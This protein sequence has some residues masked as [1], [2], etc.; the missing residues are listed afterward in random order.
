VDTAVYNRKDLGGKV[1]G[2]A[3][4]EQYDCTT[5]VYPDW[6]LEQ[7]GLGVMTLRRIN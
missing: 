7:Y 2:P 4:V 1:D 5:V 3:I 6:S